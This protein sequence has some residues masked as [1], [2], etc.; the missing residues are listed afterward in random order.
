VFVCLVSIINS[1]CHSYFIG[2]VARY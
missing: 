1:G 2:K